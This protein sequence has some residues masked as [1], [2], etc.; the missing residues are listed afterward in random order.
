[1]SRNGK[2]EDFKGSSSEIIVAEALK[3]IHKISEKQ[4]PFFVVI[5]YGSPHNPWIAGHVDKN[6][7]H[8]LDTV[9]QNHYGEIVEMDRSI[10]ALRKG[11]RDMKISENTL[12]WFNSDNGGVKNFG[13][14]TVGGLRGWKGDIYEGG[15]RVPCIVEWPAVIKANRITEFPASVMDIFPT[16]AE[17]VGVPSSEMTQPIDGISIR[18]LFDQEIKIR[19]EPI[20]FRYITKGALIDNNF[21]LVSLNTKGNDFELYDLKRDPSEK[22]NLITSENKIAQKLIATYK[23]W[24]QSVDRSMQGNDYPEGLTE[25][26]PKPQQW[27]L[28]AEYKPFLNELLKRPEYQNISNNSE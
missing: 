14:E 22:N 6:A 3:Y 16:I 10:G 19:K 20:P 2:F 15:L 27:I 13:P 28:S 26:D 7:F 21:K 5:W 8:D 1:M 24:C 18:K 4:E 17:I 9:A 12:V 11:L 25:P 23:S